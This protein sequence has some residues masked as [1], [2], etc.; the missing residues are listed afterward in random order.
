LEKIMA[1]KTYLAVK[2]PARIATLALTLLLLLL[3][4]GADTAP[5]PV[6]A[7][8]HMWGIPVV[9]P[10]PEPERR[11]SAITPNPLIEMMIDQV[12]SNT[13]STYDR[14]LAGELPVWVDNGWY[15]IP[16]RYTYSGTPIQKTTHFVGQHMA[17]LGLDVEYHQW[18][19]GTNPN[20]IGELPGMTQPDRIFIIGAHL[21]DVQG[22]PGADDNAS[23][24]VA[25]LL[26]AQ[27]LTQYN[28]DCTLRFAFWTGE[29]QYLLGSH[30]YAQ[31]SYNRGENIE[32]YLN[33]DMI[34]W[35]TIGSSRD[36]DVIYNPNLPPTHDLALLFSD[37]VNAYNIN[38]IPQ[39]GTSLSGG[40]DHASFWDYGYTAIL[41]I[42]DL[43]PGDFNPYY[44]SSQ[45]TP[46]HT[47]LGYF[48]DFVKASVGTF[49]HMG[50]LLPAIGNL[51]GTVSD[52][53]G[54]PIASAQVQAHRTPSQMWETATNPDGSYALELVSGVYTVTAQAP[55]YM[56]FS[57]SSIV[58]TDGFTSTLD[59]TL[60]ITPPFTLTGTVREE[61]SGEPLSAIVS[62][63]G[64]PIPPTHTDPA[65][66][67]YAIP[68]QQ[69]TYTLKA[70]NP[71]HHPQ[72]VVV[73]FQ[74]NQQQDFDLASICL[75]VV[76]DDDQYGSYY[77]DSLD[78]L[79]YDY[80]FTTQGPGMDA[81]PF[82][83]GI[84][85]LT[86]DQLTDTLTQSDQVTLASYLDGGG[87]LFVSG[88][89]IGQEIGSSSF[90]AEY[91]HASFSA[92]DAGLYVLNGLGF[93]DPLADIFIQGGDGAGN[94]TSPDAIAPVGDG[95]AVYQYW[96]NPL[97]EPVPYG[98]V[99]FTGAHR[100]VYFSFGFEAIHRAFDRDQVLQATLDYLG[101]CTQPEAPQASFTASSGAGGR[102]FQFTNTSQGTPLMS[103]HW[104]FGDGSPASTQA[105]PEHAYAQPGFYTVTLTVTSRYGLD[106]TSAIVF[107]PYE[108]YLP[109]VNK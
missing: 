43:P 88:Q 51:I 45:D 2:H 29:E 73:N 62:V 50:C 109:A 69:G 84:V 4:G 95:E 8:A 24:S 26:A 104:N 93:L 64:S 108:V 102:G 106:T 12:Y 98:G 46:A 63:V 20:V 41:A 40:S 71:Y 94:Q 32:G 34:A 44:H 80:Q 6:A 60:M 81:L 99:A 47:D 105:N 92:P 48:T 103:Y 52:A 86:G 91:L 9:E 33:L 87:R 27:I 38:L 75:L 3:V 5:Q 56:N 57:S 11:V 25:I 15:T 16:T 78:R 74:G 21:D 90:F 17:A 35:N 97:P 83:Q 53:E 107:M 67:K 19:S 1:L 7:Q 61:L 96:D 85:W 31:R 77:T 14:Q 18:N 22:A 89:N 79:G 58:V 70:E 65:T 10:A 59:I 42:E 49:A 39:L 66:G 37:V 13:V 82:F 101:T 72:T 28:W 23:G 36:I 54:V 76:G 30:V 55:G 100:T 68:L